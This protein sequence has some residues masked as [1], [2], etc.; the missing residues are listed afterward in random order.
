MPKMPTQQV[1]VF[2]VADVGAKN[3]VDNRSGEILKLTKGQGIV[4]EV[5]SF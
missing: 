4:V 2:T 1:D 3:S 5:L